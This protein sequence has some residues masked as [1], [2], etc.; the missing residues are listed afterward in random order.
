MPGPKAGSAESG[1]DLDAIGEDPMCEA[2]AA[3]AGW[4]CAFMCLRLGRSVAVLGAVERPGVYPVDDGPLR[5]LKFWQLREGLSQDAIFRRVKIYFS[6]P[7]SFVDL[8][9]ADAN[10]S[11][12]GI[13]TAE[14]ARSMQALWVVVPSC[15]IC[16]YVAGHVAKARN[17]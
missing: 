11:T 16:V 9:L 17:G 8:S 7:R 3:L 5:F 13:A 2:N 15:S 10:R 14:S 4:R 6:M 1:I 12:W